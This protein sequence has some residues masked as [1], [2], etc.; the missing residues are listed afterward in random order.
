MT[1]G[2]DRPHT[3]EQ[4]AGYGYPQ[5]QAPGGGYGYPQAGQPGP[6]Q[7]QPAP[8]AFGPFGAQPEPAGFTP[9]PQ[10]DWQAMADDNESRRSRRKMMVISG[11]A[12]AVVLAAV[13]GFLLFGNVLSDDP[14][15]QDK[16]NVTAS[17][18]P[19]PAP[20]ESEDTS[21][22][23]ANEP[24][25]LRDRGNAGP[26]V[27]LAMASG[28]ELAKMGTRD[29]LRLKGGP[30]SYAQGAEPAIDVTKSFTITTR[31]YT[32]VD[33]GSRMAISQGDGASFSYELGFEAANGKK[34]WVFRVQTGDKG[35]AATAQQVVADA[36]ADPEKKWTQLTGTYDAGTK[37]ITLYV[38]DKP[39]GQAQV[40]GIWAGPGP[41]QLGRA[42]HHGIWSGSWVG[43]LDRIRFWDKALAPD[44]V[45]ILD[46]GKL[47]KLGKPTH[48]WLI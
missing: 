16:P 26:P 14:K 4:N 47:D 13:G 17:G 7:Q 33:N 2:T 40:P 23:V 6:F 19:S 41:L 44:Q 32:V 11:S 35:A 29:E 25:L 30:D 9:S 21:P 43:S 15:G 12:V 8:G 37:T 38:N 46:S 45:A 3:P 31:V 18:S 28:V 36:G 42:R 10:P 24:N 48:A 39:A 20:S 5:G 27:H 1:D 34:T 22:T